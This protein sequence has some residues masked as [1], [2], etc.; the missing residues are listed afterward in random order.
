MKVLLKLRDNQ[1]VNVKK[2]PHRAKHQVRKAVRKAQRATSLT[3][4]DKTKRAQ[5]KQIQELNDKIELKDG[6]KAEN[7]QKHLEILN[8]FKR[9]VESSYL[10]D[11][12]HHSKRSGPG[13][14]Q[15]E[16]PYNQ[17]HHHMGQQLHKRAS[18]SMEKSKDIGRKYI[19]NQKYKKAA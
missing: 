8:L 18:L 1:G 2:S 19:K 4:K 7:A 14:I 13:T 5:A 3:R 17:F 6:W 11:K 16:G 15:G 10:K 12:P 9:Q